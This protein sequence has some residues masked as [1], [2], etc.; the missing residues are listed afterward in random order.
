MEYTVDSKILQQISQ[1]R[2]L[3]KVKKGFDFVEADAEHTLQQQLKLVMIESPTFE[4]AE[5]AKV[6]AEM[7]RA[8]GLDNVQIDS[9]G[10]TF[11][12]RKG[13]GK[14]PTILLE[15]HLDTVFPMGTVKE[16]IR[17]D[18]RIYCPG[19]NDDTRGCVNVLAVLRAINHAGLETDG[20]VIF[21]GTVQEEGMGGFGGMKKFLAEHKEIGG[22]VSIDGSGMD[23]I[24]YEAT[25][26]RTL[27]V[28]FHGIGG[29]AMGAF[30]FVA[31][32]L[33]AAAR[34]VTKIAD[35]KVPE[36][37]RTTYAV[38]NFHAGNDAGIHAI[39]K[40]CTIKINFRSN[41]QKELEELEA[42]IKACVAEACAEETARWGKDTITYD[43]EDYVD[44]RAGTQSNK[45]PIVQAAFSVIQSLGF[46]PALRQGGSTNA[47]IPVALGIPGVCLGRGGSEG[48]VHTVDEWFNPTDAHKGLQAIY[49]L[50]LLLAGVKGESPT[51]LG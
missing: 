36:N 50:T 9:H 16:I 3:A 46:N 10:N 21:C 38:S 15:G 5:R 42:K 11:G 26:I 6:F 1:L 25:G 24:V 44:N 22:S 20:D 41:G 45:A 19:I 2:G 43:F 14:G 40:E 28:N 31:N 4:E 8:E 34:A 27:A 51:I 35:I 18:G 49:L 23:G 30:G 48:G 37:P 13:T 7:L 33:H 39:V 12:V 32:P 29:H 47:S 17:K